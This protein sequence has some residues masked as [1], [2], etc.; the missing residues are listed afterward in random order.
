MA[1]NAGE[2]SMAV[3]AMTMANV[4]PPK[5]LVNSPVSTTVAALT[6]VGKILQ[7]KVDEPNNMADNFTIQTIKGPLS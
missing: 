7:P 5:R 6:S 3:Q 4:F 2:Q 1:V